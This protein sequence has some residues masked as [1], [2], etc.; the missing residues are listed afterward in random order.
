MTEV[1][2]PHTLIVKKNVGHENFW[3]D[4]A[5]WDFFAEHLENKK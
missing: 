2:I 1:G 4:N 3:D 5:I